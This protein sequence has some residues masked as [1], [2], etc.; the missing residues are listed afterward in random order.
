MY[1]IL[2]SA[3]LILFYSTDFAAASVN[4]SRLATLAAD[5]PHVQFRFSAAEPFSSLHWYFTFVAVLLLL[6]F[7][8]VY[9]EGSSNMWFHRL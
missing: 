1:W 2:A 5:V 9:T 6:L 4:A 7:L 3:E 8:F